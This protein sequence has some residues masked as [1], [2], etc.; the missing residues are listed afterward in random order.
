MPYQPTPELCELLVQA[1]G[2]TL[3]EQASRRLAEILKSDPDALRFY[4]DYCQT[5]AILAWEHGVL[6]GLNDCASAP[7]MDEK[8]PL[9]RRP[10][11]RSKWAWAVA[12]SILLAVIAIWPASRTSRSPT[13]RPMAWE[14]REPVGTV[15][16]SV[17]G[18]LSVTDLGRSLS[19]GDSLRTGDYLLKDGVVELGFGDQVVLVAESPACFSIPSSMQVVLEEGKITARVLAT[20]TEFRVDTPDAE[21]IDF[22][23]EFA[24]DVTADLKTE[25]HVFDGR[26]DVKPVCGP[27][28]DP[29]H[30]LANRATCVDRACSIP[31]GI[32]CDPTRF[33]RSLDEPTARYAEMIQELGPVMYFRMTPPEDGRTL[34][35]VGPDALH[36]KIERDSETASLFAAGRVGQALHLGGPSAKEYAVVPDY[37]KAESDALTVM[38]WILADSRP[39]WASIAKNWTK[40]PGKNF[41]GQFHFGLYHDEGDLEAHVHNSKGEEVWVREEG[42]PLPLGQWHHVA[43]VMDGNT[44]TLYRNGAAVAKSPCEGLGTFAPPALGIGA[45]LDENAQAED[46]KST[47]FWDGRIDELAVFNRA[48][49][50]EQIQTLYESGSPSEDACR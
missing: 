5:H 2:D 11:Y 45:K 21:V 22:G 37:P 29:V 42:V 3:N 18:Q 13:G 40:D 32:D 9:G 33:I 35:D 34:L 38:A 27:D 28:A 17:G 6:G 19:V 24:V 43:F 39:R 41:G 16:R 25:V 44:L 20:G 23:T 14:S 15:V 26:V 12:A 10:L 4:I 48:L 30:L 1:E 7:A 47:G 31:R 8:R 49:A 36:G 46:R 50:P